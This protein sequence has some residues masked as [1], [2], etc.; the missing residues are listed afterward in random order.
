MGDTIAWLHTVH[1]QK[2]VVFVIYP[3]PSIP[4]FTTQFITATYALKGFKQN[5]QKLLINVKSFQLSIQS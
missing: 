2:S 4:P 5:L 1:A 3:A